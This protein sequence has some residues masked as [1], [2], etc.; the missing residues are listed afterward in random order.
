MAG[1]NGQKNNSRVL[2]FGFIYKGQD[3]RLRLKAKRPRN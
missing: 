2:D 3:K 1:H